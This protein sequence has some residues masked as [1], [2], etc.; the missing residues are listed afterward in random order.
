M[1]TSASE[2]PVLS[3]GR[4]NFGL[5]DPVANVI[6]HSCHGGKHH[7]HDPFQHIGA[8]TCDGPL[9]QAPPDSI[10]PGIDRFAGMVGGLGRTRSFDRSIVGGSAARTSAIVVR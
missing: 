7:A 4:S 10:W 8:A 9:G 2:S 6:G 1:R 5:T 3:S